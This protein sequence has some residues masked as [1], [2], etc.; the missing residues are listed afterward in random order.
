MTNRKFCINA[1]VPLKLSPKRKVTISSTKSDSKTVSLEKISM[2]TNKPLAA[3]K[4]PSTPAA[5]IKI[6]GEKML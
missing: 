1:K 6:T 2:S 5:K 3:I 4:P